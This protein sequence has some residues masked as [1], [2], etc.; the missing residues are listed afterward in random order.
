MNKS[1]SYLEHSIPIILFSNSKKISKTIKI[2]RRYY[3]YDVIHI[4]EASQI[5]L[6]YIEKKSNYLIID[7]L[8]NDKIYK[9]II[10]RFSNKP[11]LSIISIVNETNFEQIKYNLQNEIYKTYLNKLEPE[12]ISL[13]IDTHNRKDNFSTWQNAIKNMEKSK[14]EFEQILF[15]RNYMKFIKTIDKTYVNLIE[16]LFDTDEVLN[17]LVHKYKLLKLNL[18]EELLVLLKSYFLDLLQSNIGKRREHI[19]FIVKG[20]VNKYYSYKPEN[21]ILIPIFKI[22]VKKLKEK[23]SCK[24]NHFRIITML[25][26]LIEIELRYIGLNIMNMVSNQIDKKTSSIVENTIHIFMSSTSDKLGNYINNISHEYM[27]L[28]KL[29]KKNMEYDIDSLDKPFNKFV[30]FLDN[31][32]RLFKSFKNKMNDTMNVNDFNFMLEYVF[33]NGLKVKFPKTDIFIY[34]NLDEEIIFS[35]N[36]YI[37]INSIYAIIENS[38]ESNSTEIKF[39]LSNNENYIYVDIIDNGEGIPFE[40]VEFLF[41]KNFSYKKNGHDGLGLYIAKNWLKSIYCNLIFCFEDKKMRI[42]IPYKCPTGA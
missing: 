16:E 7:S 31:Q 5:E 22:I 23:I 12:K 30:D 18:V 40:I 32:S 6:Y 41:E 8:D 35:I 36:E 34:N 4:T 20:L 3:K 28:K 27:Y 42:E 11:H 37:L 33:K 24:K 19:K 38:I 1:I 14:V 17:E 13:D 9:D 39:I 2:F 25:E 21:E 29:K 15:Y 26:I 10:K